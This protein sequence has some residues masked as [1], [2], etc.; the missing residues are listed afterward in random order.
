MPNGVDLVKGGASGG[1]FQG[2]TVALTGVGKWVGNKL[3]GAISVDQW[4]ANEINKPKPVTMLKSL[5]LR[6]VTSARGYNNPGTGNESFASATEPGKPTPLEANPATA[7]SRLFPGGMAPGSDPGEVNKE[8]LAAARKQ[9]K[10]VLDFVANEFSSVR[11]KVSKENWEKLDNHATVVR[12]LEEKLA[13]SDDKPAASGRCSDLTK[14]DFPSTADIEGGQRYLELFDQQSSVIQA[15]FA[16]DLSRVAMLSVSFPPGAIWG[17]SP[18]QF[19]I[20]HEHQF[21]HTHE[22]HGNKGETAD[23]LA[24]GYKVYAQLFAQLLKK[25]DSVKEEDGTSVLD[26]TAVLW[27][28]QI[29]KGQ[30]S[31]EGGRWL[32]AGSMGGTFKTGRYLKDVKVKR[33]GDVFSSITRGMGLGDF[34]GSPISRFNG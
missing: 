25:L 6:V 30:H 4:V 2:E 7:F 1:H 11:R 10:S 20:D 24:N 12:G 3:P 34:N 14:A 9:K 16:C 13:L 26:N 22:N 27:A 21:V 8:A 17:F 28:G 15:A 31:I 19:G 32:I 18:G 33:N 5:D 23:I 29:A